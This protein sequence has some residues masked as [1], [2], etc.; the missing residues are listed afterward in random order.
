MIKL[1]FSQPEHLQ[2]LPI[3]LPSK[4]CALPFDFALD[5]DSKIIF[6]YHLDVE[7]YKDQVLDFLL[8]GRHKYIYTES[9]SL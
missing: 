4:T 1:P 9:A 2:I 8:Y 5:I 3:R 6:H 7:N